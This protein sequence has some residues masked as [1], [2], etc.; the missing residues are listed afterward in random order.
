M[1][2]SRTRMACL[3]TSLICGVL[4]FMHQGNFSAALAARLPQPEVQIAGMIAN[5]NGEA[6]N[7]KTADGKIVE[8]VLN[9]DTKIEKPE[10]VVGFRKQRLDVTALAP[11]LSVVAQGMQYENDQLVAKIVTLSPSLQS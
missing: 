3:L 11:G 10:G 9:P 5:R 2:P 6:M 8:V 7:V 1:S 4:T